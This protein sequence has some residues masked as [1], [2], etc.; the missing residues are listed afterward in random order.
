MPG[1]LH[2]PLLAWLLIPVALLALVAAVNLTGGRFSNGPMSRRVFVVTRVVGWL[3][4][5]A[6]GLAVFE[7]AAHRP[8]NW[9]GYVLA[10]LLLGLLAPAAPSLVW[11]H[12]RYLRWWHERRGEPKG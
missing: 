8:G 7:F 5:A 10:A 4:V 6:W 3:S 2:M 11:S 1:R 9:P 12:G